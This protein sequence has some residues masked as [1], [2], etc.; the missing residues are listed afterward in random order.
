MLLPIVAYGHPTLKKAAADITKDYPD[1]GNLIANMWETMYE[2]KGVGLAAPQVNKPIRL[3]LVDADSFNEEYPQIAGFKKVFINAHILEESGEEWSFAEGCLSVPGINE[4]VSRK[5][6]L[7]ISYVDENFEPHTESYDGIVARIIQHEYD[8]IDGKL[9][10]ERLTHFKKM[11][12]KGKL[13]DI[14]IG[15]VD[16]SYKMIFPG[17]RKR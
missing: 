10:V 17:L 6:N 4:E 11:L 5:S 2:A 1:L 8:H 13:S 3:F 7:T 9:F 14:S 15:K 12:L 16:V